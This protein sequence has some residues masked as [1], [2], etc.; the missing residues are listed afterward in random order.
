M[1]LFTYLW[2]R[3]LFINGSDPHNILLWPGGYFLSIWVI[4]PFALYFYQTR[5]VKSGS[6]FLQVHLPLGIIFGTF[7]LFLTGL[8]IILLERFFQLSEHY[9]YYEFGIYLVDSWPY[10]IDGVLWYC[11]YMLLFSFVR[12][13]G[14]L[15]AEK[16]K[17]E[18]LQKD[19]NASDL[20]VL[21]TELNPHFLFNAMNSIAMK[22]RLKENKVAVAMIASL[23]DLLRTVLSRK[24]DKMVSL[25]EEIELLNKYLMIENVRFGEQV[26]V[27]QR[28]SDGLM[29]A[30]VPQLILQPLVENA[31]KH[32]VKDNMNQQR[33]SITGERSHDSLVLTVFNTTEHL[34]KF[35]VFNGSDGIGLPNVIH[36]L[37]SHYGTK[38]QFQSMSM[39]T[40][41]AFRMTIPF[42]LL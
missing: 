39:E 35:E 10:V 18:R 14:K 3:D 20:S 8:L 4:S 29:E 27:L 19:L 1:M 37:R 11:G 33:I 17:A 24:K 15:K 34:K 31:F 2:L 22:V 28:Y 25:S 38:F 21:R 30:L 23:N 7:H 42:H 41:I 12:N 26:E 9:N 6:A 5:H 32:G 16:Q 40:G 36:R 13:T